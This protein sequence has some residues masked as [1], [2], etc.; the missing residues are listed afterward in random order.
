MGS[1]RYL[2][3]LPIILNWIQQTLDAHAHERRA[4]SSFNF[5]RLPHY[6]S[7]GLLNT[8][9][10]SPSVQQPDGCSGGFWGWPMRRNGY[11]VS[12]PSV[13]PRRFTTSPWFWITFSMLSA[14]FPTAAARWRGPA[15]PWPM[16]HTTPPGD[17]AQGAL[18]GSR[19]PRQTAAHCG[20]IAL[21]SIVAACVRASVAKGG[22]WGLPAVEKI[23]EQTFG[24]LK[25]LCEKTTE[26]AFCIVNRCHTHQATA[27]SPCL[28]RCS[29]IYV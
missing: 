20:P 8:A 2:P 17:D 9:I 22:C 1:D 16:N 27:G 15:P 5:P 26:E 29:D 28:P 3:F 10:N 11:G 14:G 6:F 21:V 18:N 13:H 12:R 24:P 23:T 25:A 4:V 7:E 19:T